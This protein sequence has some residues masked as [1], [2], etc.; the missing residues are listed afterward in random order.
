MGTQDD[1]GP[2]SIPDIDNLP[3]TPD[4]HASPEAIELFSY[5]MRVAELKSIIES[6]ES[7]NKKLREDSLNRISFDEICNHIYRMN[8][9]V[10]QKGE[11]V[12]IL[13]KLIKQEK[14]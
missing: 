11:L 2:A 12:S 3:I 13:I 7:E 10:S 5:K 8:L 6:L 4:V 9:D 1:F 14:S